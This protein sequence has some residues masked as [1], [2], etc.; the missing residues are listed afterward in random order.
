MGRL[1]E[2]RR[3][4]FIRTGW[5]KKINVPSMPGNIM[6]YFD[7]SFLKEIPDFNVVFDLTSCWNKKVIF[8]NRVNPNM[9]KTI[10]LSNPRSATC[11]GDCY[12]MSGRI[13]YDDSENRSFSWPITEFNKWPEDIKTFTLRFIKTLEDAYYKCM[14]ENKAKEKIERAVKEELRKQELEEV[15]IFFGEITK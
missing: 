3:K 11:Y 9:Q 10:T 7:S 4:S 1:V 6:D 8:I 5:F 2:A 15:K 14:E 13:S 12:T